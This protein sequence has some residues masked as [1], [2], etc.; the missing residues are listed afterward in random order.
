[1]QTT[2][3]S[4]LPFYHVNNYSPTV[5]QDL[6][7]LDFVARRAGACPGS[8]LGLVAYFLDFPTRG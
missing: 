7:S 3:E 2:A 8:N 5:F 1:M 6:C 4:V